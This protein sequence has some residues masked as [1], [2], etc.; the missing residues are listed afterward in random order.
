MREEQAKV[1]RL[2]T[3]SSNFW[4]CLQTI[5]IESASM[6]QFLWDELHLIGEQVPLRSLVSGAV[7]PVSMERCELTGGL[8]LEYAT[9]EI[10]TEMLMAGYKKLAI[11]GVPRA[12]D[13]LLRELFTHESIIVSI[14]G[15]GD[16]EN[17]LSYDII[18]VL[19]EQEVPGLEKESGVMVYSTEAQ[20]LA[21]IL[22]DISQEIPNLSV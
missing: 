17:L 16:L 8:D 6:S 3:D 15:R 18:V 12:Y 4:S 10:I 7:L 14:L 22:M 20:S 2:L 13:G 5:E 21:A 19:N 9:R 1:L 11:I